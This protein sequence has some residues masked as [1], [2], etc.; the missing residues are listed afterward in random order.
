MRYLYEENLTHRYL[1]ERNLNINNMVNLNNPTP[2][3]SRDA[4]P[5]ETTDGNTQGSQQKN[6]PSASVSV[7]T[8]AD[9]VSRGFKLIKETDRSVIKG[10]AAKTL[11]ELLSKARA[12][13]EVNIVLQCNSSWKL[14]RSPF[15]RSQILVRCTYSSWMERRW[16]TRSTLRSCPVR[17]CLSY[18]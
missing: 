3:T 8:S 14:K 9:K 12:K 18:P 11:E 6:L 17:L 5:T 7:S 4:P 10:V 15:F 2:S 13:L 16:S 1:R